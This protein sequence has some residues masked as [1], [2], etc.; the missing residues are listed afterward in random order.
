VTLYGLL[1]GTLWL[2]PTEKAL[3]YSKYMVRHCIAPMIEVLYNMCKI[4]RERY[5]KFREEKICQV[6]EKEDTTDVCLISMHEKFGKCS[7]D[8]VSIDLFHL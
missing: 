2:Y 1:L 7:L 5:V 8:H 6:K 3:L 4:Y